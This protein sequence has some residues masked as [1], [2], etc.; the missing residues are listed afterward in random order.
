MIEEK[1]IIGENTEYPL[2]G[3]LVLPDKL[4][5]PVPAVVLVHGS[6]PSDMD[7]SIGKVKP[8]KDL[9]EGLSKIGIAVLRYNKRTF[10]HK[11]AFMKNSSNITVKEE[12]IEDAILATDLLRNDCRV[13]SNNI[14]IIGHSMGG[15]LAPRIDAEGGNYKGLVILAGSPRK[16]E[17]IM[18]DQNNELLNSMN[19]VLQIIAGKQIKKI[20]KKFVNIYNLTDEEAKNSSITGKYVKAYYFK[21][22]GEHPSPNYLKNLDKPI[23]IM[24]G[25]K[26]IQVSIE[27]DFNKYKDLLKDKDKVTFKVYENLNHAFMPYTYESIKNARKEYSVEKHIENYVINDIANWILSN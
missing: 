11:K 18:I 14:F 15:M 25:E 24:Q 20:N 27:K 26:D 10:A 23:L 12:T 7:E 5:K 3:I 17:E 13:D 1:V 9:A 2:D 16:L 8:F 21:E 19:K 4:D 6:G 22:M